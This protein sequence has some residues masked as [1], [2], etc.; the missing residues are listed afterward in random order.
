MIGSTLDHLEC[1]STGE[2]HDA[3][4]LHTTSRAGRPLLARYDLE[5]AA[6]T[7]SRETLRGRRWDLW[8][9]AEVLPVQRRE[10]IVTLGEGAT[11]LLDAPGLAG[12]LGLPEGSVWVKDEGRNPTGTFKARGLALAVSRAKELGAAGVAV[13]TAGNAG[14]AAAAYAA[15]AD[16]PCFVAMP[17]DAPPA[18]AAEVRAFGAELELVD[19]L[20]H[21]AGRR[22]AEVV[23]AR[24]L[25]D[26]ATL[27]E[28]YRAEGKKTMGYELWEQ[29]GDGGLPEVIVYPTGGGTGLIGM[30]KAFAELAAM[31]LL[32]A[33]APL[34]RMVA[35]QS[36]G[37]APVVRAVEQGDARCDPWDEA[38]TLAPGIR[39]PRVFADDLVLAA[40]RE[41]GGTALAV[42]DEEIVRGVRDLARLEGVDASPEGG[43]TL[44]G[45]RRLVASGAL[46]P[47]ERAVLF[48][49]GTGLKH[50]ELR[51]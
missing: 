14:A 20:I 30:W 16:L 31:G 1:S 6:A 37:C 8:R 21:D 22:V 11:P 7:L 23:A 41:S 38:S 39:V 24:G 50:P 4:R 12:A 48:V 28:P 32:P 34:P 33:D 15:R 40:L 18:V 3:T 44:A 27:R 10:N 35:V 46:A 49:C 45:L 26:L 25:L 19:G 5:R 36:T 51:P 9:Y 29:L 13:P 42:P 17:R 2:R 47:G 43:A